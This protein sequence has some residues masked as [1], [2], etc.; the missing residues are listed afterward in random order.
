MADK[1][2]QALKRRAN[3]LS[4]RVY[5]RLPAP[6]KKTVKKVIGGAS[7]V[8]APTLTIIVPVYNVE[9]YVAETLDSLQRQTLKNWEAIIVNDGSTDGSAE[10]VDRYAKGDRRIQVVHQANAGLGAAR[11]VGIQHARGRYLTFLDSDDIIPDDAYAAIVESLNKSKSDFAV[12]AVHRIRNGKKSIPAWTRAVHSKN[13]LGISI[14]EF[15]DAMMDVLACNRVF[16]TSFWRESIGSFPEGIAYEDH[17]VMVAAFIRS[18]KFDLLTHVT[19]LW[20][21]REDEGSISQQKHDLQNLL[22]RIGAK[23]DA[24]KVVTAEASDVVRAAWL[25]RVLDQDIPL[26]GEHALRADSAYRDAV[27]AFAMRYAEMADSSI[28]AGV[29]WNQRIKTSLMSTGDWESLGRFGL[30]LKTMGGLPGSTISGS[31]A[32]LDFTNFPHM[33]SW[34]PQDAFV[35]GPRLT[36]LR[37]YIERAKWDEGSWKLSGFAFVSYVPAD[38]NDWKQRFYLSNMR[39]DVQID[40]PNASSATNYFATRFARHGNFDYSSTGFELA[41]DEESLL[42]ASSTAGTLSKDRWQLRVETSTGDFS[43]DEPF[44]FSQKSGSAGWLRAKT[45]GATKTK[46]FPEMDP[47]HGLVIELRNDAVWLESVELGTDGFSGAISLSATYPKTPESVVLLRGSRLV[48]QAPLVHNVETGQYEFD[49]SLVSSELSRGSCRLRLQNLDGSKRTVAWPETAPSSIAGARGTLMR[50]THGYVDYF[51]AQ[52]I[53]FATETTINN[54]SVSVTVAGPGMSI[55]DLFGATLHQS[56]QAIQ[57]AQV[58]VI[59]EIHAKLSFGIKS[60]KSILG[61]AQGSYKLV[62]GGQAVRP[63]EELGDLLPIS[64][65]SDSYRYEIKHAGVNQ[66]RELVVVIGAPLAER[67]IGVYSQLELRRQYL[68]ETPTIIHGVLFQCYRGE[69]ASD[70]QLAIHQELTRRGTDLKLYWGVLNSNVVVPDNAIPVIIGSKMWYEVLAGVKYLC[71]NIDFDRFF[72]K[73]SHQRFLQTFHG[74]AFKAMGIGFWEDK[75]FNTWEVD[76]EVAR[77]NTAWD[78]IVLPNN[79]SVRYYEEQYRFEGEYLVTGY[80]RNDMIVNGSAIEAKAKMESVYGIPSDKKLLLYAPTWRDSSATGAW[81]ATMFDEL[82]IE[83]LADSLGDDYVLLI[84]GHNYNL[85]EQSRVK[86]SASVVDVTDYPEIN[87]LILAADVAL[88]DYSSLRF[89]WA[90][91]M[92]PMLF[93]V[94]DMEEYLSLRPGLFP[95]EESA[96]GPLLSSTDEVIAAMADLSSY[97]DQYGAELEIFNA[98]FNGLSDGAASSRVVDTFFS[99]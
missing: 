58:D 53:L 7:S 61:G 16:R 93:F 57:V 60:V 65:V 68:A 11:N 8:A 23:D 12:G 62:I 10:I 66:R 46:V 54:D 17:K 41:I 97:D 79:E 91:T 98:R 15:P 6:V 80:P 71:N 1:I 14:E 67:E 36:P 43:R 18:R 33:E 76:S 99:K 44:E 3:D 42:R 5:R 21:I 84:R 64:H 28:W 56:K 50:S 2:P 96:P 20:R 92:K 89:D 59:D 35:L 94:P 40:L 78:S 63:A 25:T 32:R 45:L 77:R 13:R 83:K 88:V 22:D 85:R 55:E 26:Y 38:Q 86:R 48:T 72:E 31:Q 39:T 4:R 69:T 34:L 82:D 47:E 51:P 49:L 52:C 37:A 90:L 95:Y 29:R 19:Y 9:S 24:F 87:D 81:S 30:E 73:K 27:R 74:H 75:G 70:N